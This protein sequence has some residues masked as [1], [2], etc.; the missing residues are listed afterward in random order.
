MS[1]S[2]RGIKRSNEFKAKISELRKGRKHSEETKEKMRLAH[3][4]RKQLS[5]SEQIS[6]S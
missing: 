6:A 3:A 1:N 2:M 5:N 4:R